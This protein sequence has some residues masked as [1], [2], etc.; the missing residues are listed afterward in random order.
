[1]ACSKGS[2]YQEQQCESRTP[3]PDSTSLHLQ[4]C[5]N[6]SR[7]S[8]TRRECSTYRKAGRDRDQH[9][10]CCCSNTKADDDSSGRGYGHGLLVANAQESTDRD[11]PPAPLVHQKRAWTTRY[12]ATFKRLE[13]ELIVVYVSCQYWH[14]GMMAETHLYA[15]MFGPTSKTKTRPSHGRK[16][17]STAAVPL[18]R[19]PAGR[20]SGWNA[21]RKKKYTSV[22][23]T[24]SDG[25]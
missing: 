20:N 8:Q 5:D 21:P 22:G 11:L 23:N 14:G 17:A 10:Q 25:Y 9:S 7:L 13:S 24:T 19:E 4:V 18:A 15:Q 6:I 12:S 2:E 1:M 16:R 3:Q